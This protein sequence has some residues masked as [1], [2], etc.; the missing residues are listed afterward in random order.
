[1]L[2]LLHHD[3]VL[4]TVCELLG[5]LSLLFLFLLELL[6]QVVELLPDPLLNVKQRTVVTALTLHIGG[7]ARVLVRL[8]AWLRVVLGTAWQLLLSVPFNDVG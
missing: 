3:W 2:V 6:S 7:S 1:M 8:Y 4:V 5:C